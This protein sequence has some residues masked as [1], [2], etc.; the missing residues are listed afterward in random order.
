MLRLNGWMN[1]K[2]VNAVSMGGDGVCC[3][4]NE[5]DIFVFA[6]AML[7]AACDTK[8]FVTLMQFAMLDATFVMM[9]VTRNALPSL[10][11]AWSL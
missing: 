1:W 10:C 7:D 8:P 2:A 6:F 11:D 9:D 5:H 4:L 3:L